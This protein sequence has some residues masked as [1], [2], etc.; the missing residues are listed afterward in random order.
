MKRAFV[1]PLKSDLTAFLSYKRALGLRYARQEESLRHFDR[2]VR[3]VH[4]H[5]SHRPDLRALIQGW[6]AQGQG[7]KPGS[8]AL[9]L[10]LIRQFCLFRR[11]RDPGGFV[12]DRGCFPWRAKS[13]FVP[14]IF[15]LKEIRLLL[16]HI[17]RA[18][19]TTLQR[20]SGRLLLLVLYCT[21]LRFGEAARLKLADL[22]LDRRLLWIRESKGRTRLVPFGSDLAREFRSY[23]SCRGFSTLSAQDPLILSFQRK[24]YSSDRISRI[25]R[26]WLR[27][28]D[29][30][31]NHG[32]VGPRPYDIRH[33]FAVHRLSRW[34]RRGVTV[35][36]RLPWLSIYMGHA[37]I[38]GTEIYLTTTPEVQ[39]LVSR[40]FEA[41][42]RKRR[43]KL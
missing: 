40:R 10:K 6:L 18:P 8:V 27:K 24:R 11:R 16:R 30:K 38:L 21:G 15:S 37:N 14:H 19:G 26:G 42:F 3:R 7:R 1:S 31:T 32:R 25:I 20:L 35:C 4:S 36:G 2:Y 13:D 17:D 22:D 12:P 9:E 34:Y 23:L 33:T 29:L 41:L 5:C 28:T 43:T 39:G